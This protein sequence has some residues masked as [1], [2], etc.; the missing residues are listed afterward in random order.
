MDISS[1][2]PTRNLVS[3]VGPL[4]Q[5]CGAG[6]CLIFMYPGELC[7]DGAFDVLGAGAWCLS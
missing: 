4:C 6:R 1:S 2:I 7:F 3:V 5:Q